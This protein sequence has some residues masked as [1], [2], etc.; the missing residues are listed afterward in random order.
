MHASVNLVIAIAA[1]CLVT[2]SAA[3]P[4]PQSTDTL[5]TGPTPTKDDCAEGYARDASAVDDATA[6]YGKDPTGLARALE[7]I[8]C[9]EI[10]D[11]RGGGGTIALSPGAAVKLRA[12]PASP[13]VAEPL[14]EQPSVTKPK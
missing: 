12:A 5:A 9:G 1:V 10:G 4:L 13:L 14:K 2:P 11:G 8:P 7:L 6:L 3:A